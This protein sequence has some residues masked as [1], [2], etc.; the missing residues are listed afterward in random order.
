MPTD[1]HDYD[2]LP[3]EEMPFDEAEELTIVKLVVVFKVD[4]IKLG[5]SH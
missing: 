1:H 4:S 5:F 2:Y 3:F